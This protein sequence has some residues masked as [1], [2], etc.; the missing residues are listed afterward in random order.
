MSGEVC[1]ES[2]LVLFISACPIAYSRI[3]TS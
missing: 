3:W 1:T 2:N